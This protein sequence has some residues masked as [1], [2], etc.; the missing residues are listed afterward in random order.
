MDKGIPVATTNSFDPEILNRSAI[1]HTGQQSS[2]AGIGGEAL[3][4]CLLDKGVES[5]SI[6]FPSTTTSATSR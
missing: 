4:K 2:A 1:S 6:I 3:A 5:G